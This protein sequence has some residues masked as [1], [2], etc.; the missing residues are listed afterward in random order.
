[1]NQATALG[2]IIWIH[3]YE[4]K[5]VA[6]AIGVSRGHL[7]NIVNGRDPL[8]EELAHAIARFLEVVPGRLLNLKQEVLRRERFAK[9]AKKPPRRKKRATTTKSKTK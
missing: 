2:T 7:S 8:K 3:G 6:K 1:M 9:A 4:V 5:E